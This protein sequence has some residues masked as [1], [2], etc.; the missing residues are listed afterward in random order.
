MLPQSRGARPPL[1]PP[2]LTSKMP[3]QGTCWAGR[4]TQLL[5]N[6]IM[7]QC[8][9]RVLHLRALHLHARL[10][11]RACLLSYLH[12]C[13]LLACDAGC[14]PCMQAIS[15]VSKVPEKVWF[16]SVKGY[17][18]WLQPKPADVRT[19][20]Q[21]GHTIWCVQVLCQFCCSTLR[22]RQNMICER[23]LDVAACSFTCQGF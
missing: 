8:A 14:T 6:H 18:P 21:G 19:Q 2:Q 9:H 20:D 5:H 1:N 15:I 7:P 13:R 17:K 22:A 10:R 12:A 23:V 4:F 11:L 16:C 3:A